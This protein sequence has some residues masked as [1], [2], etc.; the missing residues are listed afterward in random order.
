M[1]KIYVA[2]SADILHIG[3]MNIISHAASLGEL[4]VGF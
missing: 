3:H 4:A 2:M 1:K